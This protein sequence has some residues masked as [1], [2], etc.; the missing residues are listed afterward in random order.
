[1]YVPGVATKPPYNNNF[2]PELVTLHRILR[3]TLAPREGDATTCLAYERNLIKYMMGEEEFNA[4]DYMLMEIWSITLNPL[5]ACG[6]APQIMCM[7]E[8]V[9]GCTIVNNEEHKT[10]R[11]Q[12]PYALVVAPASPPATHTSHFPST[13]STS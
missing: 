1:M 12:I 3:K 13:G 7:I 10:F 2:K 5:K 9:T 8:K 4:F 6:Y 11:P